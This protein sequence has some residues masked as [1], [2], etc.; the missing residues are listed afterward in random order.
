VFG[1]LSDFGFRISVLIILGA[2]LARVLIALGIAAP[3]SAAPG[4]DLPA[5]TVVVHA[6]GSLVVSTAAASEARTAPAAA[7]C[8][9]SFGQ[10]STP[11]TRRELEA[12]KLPIARTQ[13][14]K[15]G[16]RYTQV[17]LLTR[18][19]SGE[20]LPGTS[21]AMT[22]KIPLARALD[23]EAVDRLFGLE[24]DDE[25]RRVRQFWADR[26]KAGYSHRFPVAFAGQEG[27]C[28][29]E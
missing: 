14:E 9:Y 11:P 19:G 18:L 4:A 1:F 26:V 27:D 8:C 23:E 21:G 17:V 7:A 20:L 16:I 5:P 29:G 6:D 22:L 15:D 28:I 24:F 13:W 2:R 12:S 25:F 3:A 10:P